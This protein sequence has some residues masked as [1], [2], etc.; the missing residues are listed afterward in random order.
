MAAVMLRTGRLRMISLAV[1]SKLIMGGGIYQDGQKAETCRYSFYN[2]PWRIQSA[3]NS[4]GYKWVF[5]M[6]K[7]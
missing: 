3:G 5:S 4:S 1:G 2:I 7:P 6:G